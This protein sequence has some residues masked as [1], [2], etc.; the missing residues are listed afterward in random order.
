[1]KTIGQLAYEAYCVNRN[2]TS[3][4]GELLPGWEQQSPELR[5]AWEAAAEAAKQAVIEAAKYRYGDF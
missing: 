2:W 5:E 1:V 3:V 4:R